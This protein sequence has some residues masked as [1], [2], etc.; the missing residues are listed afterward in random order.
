MSEAIHYPNEKELLLAT[1]E[2]PTA[3]RE[4]Y[5]LQACMGN[6]A[7]RRRVA[8]LLEHANTAASFMN[9]PVGRLD[10]TKPPNSFEEGVEI[11][12]Y[13]L[14]EPLGEGGMGVVYV[15]EQTEPVRRKVA[16]KVIK[17]GMDSRAVIARF[18]AERQA[19]AMMDHPNIARVLDAGT[20]QARLPY[21]VMELVRGMPIT[22]FCDQAKSSVEDRLRLFIDVCAAVQHAH[23]K[24]IIHRDLKPS[25][26][27]VTLHDGRPVVKVID[28]GVAKAL[29]QQLTPHTLYTAL[30]QVVGTPL[31][32]SPEQLELS[33]L[34]I[35]TR[36]DVYALGVLFYELLT[37]TL[38][39]DRDRLMKS[40]FD[41]M[42]RIIREED[43][44]RPSYRVTHML[45]AE[46]STVAE[47]RGLDQ[48][49]LKY[50]IKSELDWIALK[51]ILKDR[52]RRYSSAADFADD[53]AR[54][55]NHEPVVAHPPSMVYRTRKFA[56]K[57]RGLLT[58]ASLLAA[59]L[60]GGSVFSF[61]YAMRAARAERESEQRLE[62]IKGEQVKT[63]E[64][65]VAVQESNAIQR[66]LRSLAEMEAKKAKQAA[67]QEQAL[68]EQAEISRRESQWNLYVAS[69]ATMQS[70][71]QKREYGRLDQLLQASIP[72]PG[73]ADFRG[74]EWYYLQL[75]VR[76]AFRTVKEL[77]N[78]INPL[79]ASFHPSGDEFATRGSENSIDIWDAS[80]LTLRRRIDCNAIV[81]EMSWSPDGKY[82]AIGTWESCEL[83][84]FDSRTGRQVWRSQPVAPRAGTAPTPYIS[85]LSWNSDGQR[86]AIAN[87]YGDIAVVNLRDMTTHLVHQ[88]DDE[89][90]IGHLAWCPDSD[91][92]AAGMRFGQRRIINT[93]DGT[94]KSLEVQSLEIGYALAW[95]P[96]GG[97]LATSEGAT[98]RIA[99]R[100]GQEICKILDS[101]A[102]VEDLA[103]LDDSSLVSASRDHSARI[104]DVPSQALKHR[105]Q[106]LDE[107]IHSVAISPDAEQLV[108]AGTTK[109]RIT[110]RA[111]RETEPTIQVIP[112][113]HGFYASEQVEKN[114]IDSIDWSP[115]GTQLMC[116]ADV[117]H[118]SWYGGV[119]GVFN[120]ISLRPLNCVNT[121][122]CS[123]ACWDPDGL[124]MLRPQVGHRLCAQDPRTGTVFQALRFSPFDDPIAVWSPSRKRVLTHVAH[125]PAW[126]R[127]GTTAQS[128]VTWPPEA[129]GGMSVAAW[130][131]SETQCVV[132]GHGNFTILHSDGT[133]IAPTDWK[134]ARC[135][136]VAWHP[137]EQ[138]VAIATTRGEIWI[139]DANTS[140]PIMRL[141]GHGGDVSGVD[142]SPDGLRLA[143]A[144]QDGTVRIWDVASGREL[145]QLT[146]PGVRGFSSVAWSPDGM[147]LAAGSLRR[148]LVVFGDVGSTQSL[149]ATE[150]SEQGVVYQALIAKDAQQSFSKP[151]PGAA[152]RAAWQD[153]RSRLDTLPQASPTKIKS[154]VRTWFEP[155]LRSSESL[156][157]Q[158]T[159]GMCALDGIANDVMAI[160]LGEELI[161][162]VQGQR[163]ALEREDFL[164][165]MLHLCYRLCHRQSQSGGLSQASPWLLLA[166]TLAAQC[167]GEFPQNQ[168]GWKLKL[169][170]QA[171]SVSEELKQYA[172][173]SE[174]PTAPEVRKRIASF[175]E[176]LKQTPTGMLPFE[177]GSDPSLAHAGWIATITEVELR[178]GR[179]ITFGDEWI[180]SLR[181][182]VLAHSNDIH[183]YYL[184]ALA[185]LVSKDDMA[186]RE[187]CQLILER[188]SETSDPLTAEFAAWTCSLAPLAIPDYRTAIDLYRRVA[189]DKVRLDKSGPLLYRMGNA[190]EARLELLQVADTTHEQSSPAYTWLYLALVEHQLG[191]IQSAQEWKDKADAYVA[192]QAAAPTDSHATSWNRLATLRILQQEVEQ[193]L[194]ET[195]E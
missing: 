185:Q 50:A 179:A 94:Y 194:Q 181:Q 73:E 23:Q 22:K 121:D 175:V 193:L 25:N 116:M 134:S 58:S 120:P 90:F 129:H 155:S 46:I 37:G 91:L 82:I 123:N 67:K 69:L 110:K 24:G 172:D 171:L 168:C 2:L 131:A 68:R 88:Q 55:L 167:T 164:E 106:I 12:R 65:L 154:A 108:F 87:R 162:L 49:T 40:G 109:I 7:L 136:G 13:R 101:N 146:A 140:A 113:E 130:N 145:L 74:W 78:S 135:F 159:A 85:G 96:S 43:P 20:T 100:E 9:S 17:P 16:L 1:L 81:R 89:G 142:F 143:S 166:N 48:S 39:F 60:L 115:D 80:T 189:G 14:M 147:Q 86:I 149:Q 57:H 104:W 191:N 103:W 93:T 28:F 77:P 128:L 124:L 15:A 98:I 132:G 75:L 150:F 126:L 152:W 173:G 51:A 138:F 97:L 119:C 182:P 18:E 161:E 148:Q 178:L 21:F 29:H 30:N 133:Y 79:W 76:N 70:A 192:E 63:R 19:L 8:D 27:L 62:Q 158:A 107:P 137:S 47:K 71:F 160:A 33:G 156:T 11:D 3:E 195:V 188:F 157:A 5:L 118:E 112:D 32:M 26:I 36:S 92:L 42:R 151:I 38:P 190:T 174:Q 111:A 44:P 64:A 187:T 72:L 6:D 170:L 66:E 95:N 61:G 102:W 176:A 99:N 139:R 10:A 56:F 180:E 114:A 153:L 53:V 105:F 45:Q 144:S 183:P 31:Y 127:D 4:S 35:D 169:M 83:L 117:F 184:L 163:G 165:T 34:D 122:V 177:V 54:Y 141:T 84:V 41:E 125:G 59:A 52:N 186:Y